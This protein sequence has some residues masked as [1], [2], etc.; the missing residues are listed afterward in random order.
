MLTLSTGERVTLQIYGF[1]QDNLTVGGKAGIT[2][3]LKNIMSSARRMDMEDSNSDSFIGTDMYN[4]LN[5][6]LY[7]SMPAE[8][9][10]A[11]KSVD[12]KASV[13]AGSTQTRT[14]SMK[15]FL[16]S[17]TE[18][19][20]RIHHSAVDEGNQYPIFTDDASRI[21]TL[22]GPQIIEWWLRSPR[23]ADAISFGLVH[24]TGQAGYTRASWEYG[25]INFG[26]CV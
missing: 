7:Q 15:I 14:D 6:S 9:R 3:G 26:F 20:G 16:F 25:G 18:C 2:F 4:W 19:F 12:K 1:D 8:L 10:S 13:G 17:E 11:I 22:L 24:S 23:K 5:G 21:K